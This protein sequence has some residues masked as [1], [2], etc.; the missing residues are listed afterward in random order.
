MRKGTV[1]R[2]CRLCNIITSHFYLSRIIKNDWICITCC[3]VNN[4]QYHLSKSGKQS[5]RLRGQKDRFKNRN[6]IYEQQLRWRH[7]DFG[8]SRCTHFSK[9]RMANKLNATPPWVDKNKIKQIYERRKVNE[10]VDHI[11][12]LKGRNVCGLH[13]HYNLQILSAKENIKKGNN[14]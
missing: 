9:M 1:H 14:L 2:L 8:R 12:P 5:K 4:A 11:I 6:R 3:K 7:T 10:H 13:V